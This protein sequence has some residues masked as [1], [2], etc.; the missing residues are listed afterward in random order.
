MPDHLNCQLCDRTLPALTAHHLIPRQHTKRR[1][2]DPG[3]TVDICAACHKQIHTLFDNRTL[4]QE[5]NTLEK[6]R[7]HPQMAKFIAWVQK[8]DPQKRVRSY[9]GTGS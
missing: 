6:L 2:Q 8:Q 1:K 7:D 5:L 3:P 9:R 4:A